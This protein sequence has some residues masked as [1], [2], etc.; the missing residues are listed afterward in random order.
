MDLDILFEGFEDEARPPTVA[1]ELP[2]SEPTMAPIDEPP[3]TG[4]TSISSTVP[5]QRLGTSI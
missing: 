1:A 3:P 2:P 4:A 5:P